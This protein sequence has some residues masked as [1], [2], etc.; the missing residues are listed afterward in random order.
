MK[1]NEIRKKVAKIYGQINK[2]ALKGKDYS[3][4][5]HRII[6]QAVEKGDYAY[7]EMCLSDYYNIEASKYG[8]VYGMKTKTWKLVLEQTDSTFI[9]KLRSFYKSK[10]I[11]QQGQE[12]RSDDYTYANIA[13]AGPYLAEDITI[14]RDH[15]T[16]VTRTKYTPMPATMSQ[17]SVS[18]RVSGTSSSIDFTI[19]DD[20][21]Y[22]ADVY[23]VIWATFSSPLYAEPVGVTNSQSQAGDLIL[24]RMK[25]LDS[26]GIKQGGIVNTYPIRISDI[27]DPGTKAAFIGKSAG[28]H[29]EFSPFKIY[30]SDSEICEMLGIEEYQ[31]AS[32]SNRFDAEIVQIKRIESVT[33]ASPYEINRIST[34]LPSGTQSYLSLGITYST[35]IPMTHGGDYLLTT[36]RR[37]DEGWIFPD[38]RYESYSYR[39][40]VRKENLLG[41][42][43]EVDSIIENP[44][45]YQIKSRYATYLG[46]KKTYLEVQRAG[47]TSSITVVYENFAQ[48]EDAN[49]FARYKIA[50]DYL[51]S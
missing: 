2:I 13:T 21:I 7:L 44:A 5:Y 31:L 24:V 9:N 16:S 1:K 39:L 4:E 28:G 48:S 20:G 26:S 15:S 45:Y 29:L 35:K 18:K 10:G 51:N 36:H 17:I 34:I 46:L 14:K 30:K 40:S 11:Y 22:K 27:Y 32:I 47:S 8:N 23:K 38:L 49:L 50:I 25:E 37:G 33:F 12:I 19:S 41:T 43:K 42:I 3:L 6:D